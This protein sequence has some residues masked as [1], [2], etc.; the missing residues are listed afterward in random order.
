MQKNNVPELV[1][2]VLTPEYA[3]WEAS[4]LMPSLSRG[5][6]DMW[7]KTY[8]IKTVAPTMG[9]VRSMGGVSVMPDIVSIMRQIILLL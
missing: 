6:F 5:G 7:E 8:N 9:P 2:F 4:L 3:D 1:L